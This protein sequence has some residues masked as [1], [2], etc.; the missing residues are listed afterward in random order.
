MDK[1]PNIFLDLLLIGV[2][3]MDFTIL[4]TKLHWT[5]VLCGLVIRLDLIERFNCGLG[6]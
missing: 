2:A 3:V 4:I 6:G 5:R 1:E